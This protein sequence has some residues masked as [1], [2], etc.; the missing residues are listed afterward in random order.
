MIPDQL[1][2][3]VLVTCTAVTGEDVA[4]CLLFPHVVDFIDLCSVC[5]PWVC[6]VH[7]LCSRLD[8]RKIL[9]SK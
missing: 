7:L 9:I 3:L 1:Q 4:A 5:L 2:Q 6:S 8:C